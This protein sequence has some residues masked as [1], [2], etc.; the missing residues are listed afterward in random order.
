IEFIQKLSLSY[1]IRIFTTRNSQDVQKWLVKHHF[2][3]YIED[4]TNK[5]EPAFAYIDDRGI[6][7]NGNYDKLMSDVKNFKP[8]WKK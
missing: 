2:D 1:E 7:F 5:K 3:R 8:Y 4:V 6:R